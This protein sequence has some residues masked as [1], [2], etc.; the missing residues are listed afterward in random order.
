M[1]VQVVDCTKAPGHLCTKTQLEFHPSWQNCIYKK[2]HLFLICTKVSYG[3]GVAGPAPVTWF[4]NTFQ[5][6]KNLLN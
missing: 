1:V 2:G 5:S 6:I 3:V 4:S